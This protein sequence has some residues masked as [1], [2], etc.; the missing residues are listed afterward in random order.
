MQTQAK[1][2]HQTS[3]R[4]RL[5]IR[6]RRRDLPYFLDLYE[7]LRQIPEVTDVEINPRTASVLLRFSP[8]SVDPV[9]HSLREMGLLPQAEHQTPGGTLVGRMER[10]L[11][12]RDSR[13]THVRT[14]LLAIMV[15]L[16]IHQFRRGKIFAPT[17]S[18][19]WYAYDLVSAHKRD[20]GH[21][22]E[23]RSD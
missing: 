12:A 17:L 18:V 10:F 23:T 4:M 21:R 6:E 9:H 3:D 1:V 22:E 19:L 14:V 11:A 7:N 13:P 5:R 16:A 8:A 20:Q 15:G 2:V